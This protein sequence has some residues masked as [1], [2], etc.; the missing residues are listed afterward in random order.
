MAAEAAAPRV[1]DTVRANRTVR[2]SSADTAD[3]VQAGAAD[4]VTPTAPDA[5]ENPVTLEAPV[6]ADTTDTARAATPH[7]VA[8]ADGPAKA[9]RSARSAR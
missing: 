7:R 8:R 2:Q 5:T 9:T 6:A 1:A 3:S 4:A